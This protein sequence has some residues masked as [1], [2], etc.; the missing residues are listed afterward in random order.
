[1]ERTY[2]R[3][4]IE[5]K[6]LYDT[7]KQFEKYINTLNIFGAHTNTTEIIPENN[8]LKINKFAKFNFYEDL[9]KFL[10]LEYDSNN[11][12]SFIPVNNS[13]ILGIKSPNIKLTSIFYDIEGSI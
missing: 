3:V 7:I 11:N 8:I 6:L 13:K 9:L 1:V 2:K 4:Y 5:Q 12:D 10:G